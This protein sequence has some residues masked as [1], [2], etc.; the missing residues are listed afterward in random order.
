VI[1]AEAIEVQDA[2][3]AMFELITL[4]VVAIDYVLTV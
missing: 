2:A 1:L 4:R 3:R